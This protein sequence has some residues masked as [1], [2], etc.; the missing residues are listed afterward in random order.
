ML[1]NAAYLLNRH[2]ASRDGR[3]AFE[4]LKAKKAKPLGMIRSIGSMANPPGWERCSWEAGL[5]VGPGVFFGVKGKTE[6]IVIGARSGIFK[7]RTVRRR[8]SEDRWTPKAM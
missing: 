6:E 4:R 1:Q 3:T 2:E 8:S 5:G 7:A